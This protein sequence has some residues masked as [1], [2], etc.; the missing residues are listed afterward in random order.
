MSADNPHLD[1]DQ[2]AAKSAPAV[3]TPGKSHIEREG[4]EAEASER[5]DG[6]RLRRKGRDQTLSF[7]TKPEIVQLIHTLATRQGL[8]MVEVLEQAITEYDKRLRGQ[9]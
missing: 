5:Q 6:R 9:R 2:L 8:M 7:K 4:R 1:M 3:S